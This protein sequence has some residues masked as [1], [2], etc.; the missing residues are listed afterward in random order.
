MVHDKLSCS[1][2]VDDIVRRRSFKLYSIYRLKRMRA[3]EKYLLTFHISHNHILSLVNYVAP[4]RWSLITKGS[5]E[6][7][8]KIQKILLKII[9]PK[10][11]HNEENLAILSLPTRHLRLDSNRIEWRVLPKSDQWQK[12]SVELNDK[13]KPKQSLNEISATIMCT[14]YAASQSFRIAFL[15]TNSAHVIYFFQQKVW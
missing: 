14:K 15:L 12:P 13:S 4:A 7:F 5:M 2:R 3:S 8:E 9:S 10:H 1:E 6:K 11:F